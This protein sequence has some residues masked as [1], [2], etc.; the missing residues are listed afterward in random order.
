[1]TQSDIVASVGMSRKWDAKEAGRQVAENTLEQL[2]GAPKFFLL[3]STIHYI[4][5]GGFEEF[6]EG[7]WDVLPSGTPLIGGTVAGFMNNYGSYTRGATALAVSYDHLDVAIGVGKNTKRNPLKAAH[8]CATMVNDSLKHTSFKNKFL[9]N[10]ISGPE[11]MKIPGQG[12]TNIIDSGFM[13]KFVNLVFGMSQYILQKGPGREDEIFDEITKVLPDHHMIL[14]ASFSTYKGGSN[15]QFFNDTILTNAIVG[16]GLAADLDLAVRTTHGMR[17]TN[18]D[19]EIT[20]LSR[21]KHII[22]KINGKPAMT[23]LMSKLN[24]PEGFLN[25]KTMYNIIPYYPISLRRNGRDV[26]VVMPGILKDSIITPCV[27][28]KGKVSI[29]TVSGRDLVAAAEDN[30]TF[31]KDITPK[32]G[33]FSSCLTILQTLGYKTNILRSRIEDFFKDNPF[34][35]IWCAGEG[36]YSPGSELTYANMSFNTAIFGNKQQDFQGSCF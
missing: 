29:L 16:L 12:Y 1:M 11:T 8:Q 35:L 27:I 32:F 13:S 9:L 7:V 20:K 26:P 18:I 17:K 24:W 5:H 34:L 4:D 33:I 30:L 10:F 36:T 23:E 21:N 3:F 22:Q 6:L 28:E 15:Y 19:F 31:F 14:G 25:Q 2:T